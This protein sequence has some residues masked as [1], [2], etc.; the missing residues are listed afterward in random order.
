MNSD[1]QEMEIAVIPPG[2]GMSTIPCENCQGWGGKRKSSVCILM[3]TKECRVGKR[4][5]GHM[6][7]EVNQNFII[8]TRVEKGQGSR[9]PPSLTVPEYD[10][11]KA[12]P[13]VGRLLPS[14]WTHWFLFT[15]F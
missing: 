10:G 12:W 11:E 1:N 14:N 5:L 13:D 2:K 3:S 4:V 6:M 7:E 9:E 8:F 15:V